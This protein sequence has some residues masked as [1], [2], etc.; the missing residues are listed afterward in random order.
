[1]GRRNAMDTRLQS[2]SKQWDKRKYERKL[3]ADFQ[4]DTKDWA[5]HLLDRLQKGRKD[6]S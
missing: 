5:S 1:M 3:R 2:F 4:D 6:E